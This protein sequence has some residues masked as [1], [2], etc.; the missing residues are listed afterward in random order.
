MRPAKL[1]SVCDDD[2]RESGGCVKRVAR[3]VSRRRE[4][5]R[6]DFFATS[7][8]CRHASHFGVLGIFQAEKTQEMG[9]GNRR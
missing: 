8:L 7:A 3:G 4:N 1:T 5:R 2:E 6:E 9:A